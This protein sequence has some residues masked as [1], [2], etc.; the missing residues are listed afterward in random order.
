MTQTKLF[1]INSNTR[2]G[3]NVKAAQKVLSEFGFEDNRIEKFE[4]QFIPKYKK[5]SLKHWWDIE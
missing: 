4:R 1:N 3:K 2:S 5:K